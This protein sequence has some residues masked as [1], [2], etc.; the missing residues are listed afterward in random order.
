MRVRVTNE[1]D[2]EGLFWV[3][4]VDHDDEEPRVPRLRKL[5]A[6]ASIDVH[7][8]QRGVLHVQGFK[9][10]IVPI[11][12]RIRKPEKPAGTKARRRA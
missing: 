1:S 8:S 5:A 6:A 7:V 9:A 12:K 3:V 4:D 10:S 11:P 2:S